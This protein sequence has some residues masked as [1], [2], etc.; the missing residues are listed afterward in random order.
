MPS[1]VVVIHVNLNVHTLSGK[2][3]SIDNAALIVLILFMHTY[4]MQK[5]KQQKQIVSIKNNEL[6]IINV[7][8]SEGLC[9]R[10]RRDR[11]VH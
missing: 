7:P 5:C 6:C 4:T 3:T 1:K 10:I 9:T 11:I 8:Q 2:G